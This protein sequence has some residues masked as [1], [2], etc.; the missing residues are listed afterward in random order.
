MHLPCISLEKVVVSFFK[1]T[2]KQ[3]KNYPKPLSQK[4]SLKAEGSIWKRKQRMFF[5]SEVFLQ[6]ALTEKIV[7][8]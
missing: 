5:F 1:Q 8:V 4:I 7:A 3:A 6:K 2:K